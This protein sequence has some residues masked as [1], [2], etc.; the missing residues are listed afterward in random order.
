MVIVGIRAR[1]HYIP[2]EIQ[3]LDGVVH[4]GGDLV[5]PQAVVFE[6]LQVDDQK[7]REAPDVD[8]FHRV[9]VLF[10]FGALPFR[11]AAHSFGLEK[12]LEALLRVK[13]N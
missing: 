6:P 10:A 7:G 1:A 3:V 9:P 13:S 4:L 11:L 2:V 5:P 12:Q 8:L